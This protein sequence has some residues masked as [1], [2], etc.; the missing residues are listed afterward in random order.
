M[1][2]YTATEITH[3]LCE[4]DGLTDREDWRV[5][6]ERVRHL[7]KRGL[8]RN[9]EQ[10]DGRGK[11]AFPEIEVFHAAVLCDLQSFDMSAHLLRKVT[12]AADALPML[13]EGDWAPS[14]MGDGVRRSDGG[15]KDAVRGT[16]AG[17]CWG[18][19]IR[20]DQP[21]RAVPAQVT[22]VFGWLDKHPTDEA[23]IAA[24]LGR[25]P[26]RLRLLLDL[27]DHFAAIHELLGT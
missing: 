23:A 26:N 22:A 18:L 2:L 9:G 8:L 10:I 5:T 27:T 11:M 24:L 17:E 20:Q 7:S 15:L 6:H 13:D 14:Q 3:I 4:A 12:E 21:G 19:T 1:K 16:A 25:A